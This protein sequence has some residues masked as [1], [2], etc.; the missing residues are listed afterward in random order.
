[1]R[2]PERLDL[3]AKGKGMLL[4]ATVL[5]GF[6][7]RGQ[8]FKFEIAQELELDITEI[9]PTEAAQVIVKHIQSLGPQPEA[10]SD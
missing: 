9:L 7:K 10:V 6:R 5:H 4:D 2:S 8:I 3:V 1:M